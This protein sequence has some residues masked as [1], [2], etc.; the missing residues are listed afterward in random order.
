MRFFDFLQA[1]PEHLSEGIAI[2]L[3]LC[4][5]SSG[6]AIVTVGIGQS[7]CEASLSHTS[8]SGC[9]TR[10]AHGLQ[11]AEGAKTTDDRHE[12]H[13]PQGARA[14]HLAVRPRASNPMTPGNRTHAMLPS[15]ETAQPHVAL[16]GSLPLP[17]VAGKVNTPGER[18]LGNVSAVAGKSVAL[19][20][21]VRGQRCQPIEEPWSAAWKRELPPYYSPNTSNRT[22]ERRLF[23][24]WS[25][26]PLMY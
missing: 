21:T 22:G 20:R 6:I 4:N 2:G 15:T 17:Y 16:A 26:N 18:L 10:R 24:L 11:S 5:R 3:E 14:W 25:H 13:L 8:R 19:F 9:P 12:Q 1:D 7:P 23:F